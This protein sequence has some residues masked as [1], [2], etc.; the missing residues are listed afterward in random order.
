MPYE[1][2]CLSGEIEYR[3][4]FANHYCKSAILTFDQIEVKFFASDFDHAFFESSSRRAQDKSIFAV[5]RAERI[6]WIGEALRDPTADLRQGWDSK[7]KRYDP[8]RRVAIVVRDYVVVIRFTGP[9]KARF[10]TAYPANN[11]IEKILTSPR[12]K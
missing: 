2:M 9:K 3:N 8:S 4:Y 12:W 6:N 7:E 1:L 10:V 5:H 11:S